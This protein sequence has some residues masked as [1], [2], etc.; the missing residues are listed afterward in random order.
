[1][2]GTSCW[3]EQ[4]QVERHKGAEMAVCSLGRGKVGG[5]AGAVLQR[6]E[7]LLGSF[8]MESIMV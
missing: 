1:M 6:A 7:A 2:S 4:D 3:T 8:V 5:Q